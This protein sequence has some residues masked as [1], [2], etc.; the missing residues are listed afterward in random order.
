M[1]KKLTYLGNFFSSSYSQIIK[2]PI[3]WNALVKLVNYFYS[4][5]LPRIEIDCSWTNMDAKQQLLELQAYVELSSLAEFW[6]LEEVGNK[7]LDVVVSCLEADQKLSTDVIH[8]AAN[9]S[10]W[11]IVGVA[12]SS[13]AHL[14]P[15]LLEAGDLEKFGEEVIEMLRKEYVRC[16]QEEL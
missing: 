6:L 5:E 10:Q 14:Y 9:L 16:S 4:G 15:K 13:I 3:G 1:L 12:V 2:V 11:K 8:Y 7:S